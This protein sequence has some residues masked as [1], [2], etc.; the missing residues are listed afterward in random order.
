MISEWLL[1]AAFVD[2]STERQRGSS[3]FAL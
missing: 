3:Y 1:E 2:T